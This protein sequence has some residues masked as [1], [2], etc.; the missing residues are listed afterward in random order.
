MAGRAVLG[1]LNWEAA[2]VVDVI[3][4]TP[5]TKTIVFD[6]P[7]VARPSGRPARR[8]APDCPTTATRPS[9]ATRSPRAP[10]G[11]RLE[12]TVER[13]D[14]G[15]VSPYL[16]DELRRGDRIELRGP[17]GGYFVWEP[18]QGGPV[19]L[20]GGG[21]GVVPLM[22]MIRT[23]RATG[24]STEMR[25]LYSSR[26]WDDII[27]RD[28]LD[29]P[30]RRPLHRRPH[31]DPLRAARLDRLRAAGRR[32]DARGARAPPRRAAAYLRLR[33]DPIRRDRRRSP[34]TTRPRPIRDQDRTLRTN[35]NLN[36]EAV[37]AAGTSTSSTSNRSAS[38]RSSSI[39]TSATAG[40]AKLENCAL[41]WST[42]NQ[43]SPFASSQITVCR[44][45]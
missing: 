6:L 28:E 36:Q 33:A 44:G 16:T 19:L 42:L 37:R 22:A 14:D 25:L 7:G 13:L 20:V 30:R 26:N 40:I 43:A 3:T 10:N 27:Y 21:S 9:A 38:F 5:R 18:R 4:E 8:R 34:R 17:V 23:R 45:A 35:R 1:R 2:E 39:P 15:E 11:T 29:A 31:A 32:R 12:L 24:S 41:G